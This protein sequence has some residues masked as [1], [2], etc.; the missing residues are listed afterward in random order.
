MLVFGIGSILGG[1]EQASEELGVLE[2]FQVTD[3]Q[4]GYHAESATTA[5]KL[6]V[7]LLKTPQSVFVIN[8]ALIA[9]QQAFR[10]DQILQ[11]DSSVQKRNN[12]LGAYS[13]YFIRGFSLSNS[14]N[15]LRNGRTFFHLASVPVEILNRVEVLKGPSSV[16]YGTST[17]GGMIN[18]VTK[19]PLNEFGGF[20]KGT[21][22]SDDLYHLHADVSGPLTQDG[23]LS[24]RVSAVYEDSGYFRKFADGSDFEAERYIFSTALRWTP[25]E[26]TTIDLSFDVTEDDRPQDT[27]V[28]AIG[29]GVADIPI[30][31]I[32]TQPW[33]KYDSDVWNVNLDVEHFIS[34]SFTVASGFSFQDYKR[35]RYDNQPVQIDEITGDVAFR[36]R[37]R[38][39][40]WEVTTFYFEGVIDLTTGPFEHKILAGADYTE[41][42]TDSNETARSEFFVTNIFSPLVIPDPQIGV[43]D[44]KVLGN[45]ERI[46]FYIQDL[47][48]FGE[49]WSVLLGLRYDNTEN[50][51]SIA[52]NIL[53]E[54]KADNLTPRAGVVYQP[55]DNISF[56]ASYSESF[57]PNPVVADPR[58]TNFGEQLDPTT[59]EQ[60]EV[61]VKAELYD[62]NLLLSSALFQTT[63]SD[64][65]FNDPLANALVLRGEQ[66]HKGIEF[67]ATGLI[68]ESLGIVGSFAYLDAEFTEDDDPSIV[69][70]TPSG[71]AEISASLWAEYEF[72]SGPLADLSLQAGW[73]YEDDRPG[74]N[75]NTFTLDSYHR[76]DVG[77]KYVW[78]ADS[79]TPVTFRLTASNLFDEV[80]YKGDTRGTVNPE[81]PREVRFSTQLSF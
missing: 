4:L 35:D 40:R 6:D 33:S 22:G 52:G 51:F 48:S 31:R 41:I 80:Y 30:E 56:Y 59:G 47:I 72:S 70:N 39:N 10:L 9:D 49:D 12:F 2:E 58:L 19:T 55:L 15:Y 50:D 54:G 78:R 16:L 76:V 77:L 46:G 68:G 34:D 29:D 21:V 32:L 17:P 79:E 18:M 73:F 23:E 69:G 71:V 14:S 63:R 53:R 57:E 5:L 38:I 62:G 7:P 44:E 3:Q 28:V 24:Y 37:R 27:G 25:S 81:R 26:D 66:E 8:D 13:S 67:T 11:N 60:F 75:A 64:I 61:G 20:I 42:A 45:E 43:R 1:Q 36:S 65:P 74:D